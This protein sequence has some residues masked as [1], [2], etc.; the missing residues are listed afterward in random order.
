MRYLLFLLRRLLSTVFA[1]G[2]EAVAN[3]GHNSSSVVGAAILLDDVLVVDG[4]DDG[5]LP[6]FAR[7]LA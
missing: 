2:L 5:V 3:D 1:V 7:H 6:N 4:S